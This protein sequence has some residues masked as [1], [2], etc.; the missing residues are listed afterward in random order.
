[1]GAQVGATTHIHTY[2]YTI[3]SQRPTYTHTNTHDLLSDSHSQCVCVHACVC[4]TGSAGHRP[5]GGCRRR[6][7]SRAS[8][9]V[10]D[11][12]VSSISEKFGT[13]QITRF[14]MNHPVPPHKGR[15]AD[16]GRT[17]S[18][19]SRSCTPL[20]SCVFICVCAYL[21]GIAIVEMSIVSSV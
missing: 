17:A 13:S 8:W 11:M 4:V 5:G 2:T 16:L 12:C 6:A 14:A 19:Q 3:S 15:Y 7:Q 10:M 1:M 18:C 9:D 21:P 20:C